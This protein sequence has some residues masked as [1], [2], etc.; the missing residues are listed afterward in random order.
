MSGGSPDPATTDEG[1]PIV[2]PPFANREDRDAAGVAGEDRDPARVGGIVLAAGTSDRFGDRN[3]LLATVDG[4]PLVRHAAETLVAAGLD[5]IVAVVGHDAEDVT[6]ALDGLDVETVPNPAYAQGQSSSVRVGITALEDR[7]TSVDAAVLA[8]GDMPFVEPATVEALVAAYEAGV[9]DALAAAY[10]GVRGNPVLFDRRFFADLTDVEGDV[11]GRKILL[12][13]DDSA[14]VA[15]SDE[16]VRHDID[17]PT[18]L[19]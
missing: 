16:G 11:G 18:D 15:V 1:L 19:P 13:S 14:C 10:D 12:E 3:K 7:S 17:E 8:L 2:A 6:A 4:D 5:P 9:G